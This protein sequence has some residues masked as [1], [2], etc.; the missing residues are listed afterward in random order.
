MDND[1]IKN[2]L[3]VG[4]RALA[5]V[6]LVYTC[7]Q[8]FFTPPITSSKDFDIAIEEER[9]KLGISD[10]K[11][12]NISW[13]F[14]NPEGYNNLVGCVLSENGKHT[15]FLGPTGENRST[16]KHELYHIWAGHNDRKP[17]NVLEDAIQETSAWLYQLY[18]LKTG[19]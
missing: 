11:M 17:K 12:N 4:A 14:G 10:E 6:G 8:W 18:G 3:E 15:L 19:L 9:K 1:T 7:K 2:C 5:F 13:K 16:L